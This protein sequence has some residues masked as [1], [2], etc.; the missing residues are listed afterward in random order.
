MDFNNIL[1]TIVLSVPGFLMAIV[2][3]EWAHAYVAYRFGD[4]TALK[5]GRLT[6]NPAAHYDMLGTVIFPLIGVIAGFAAIG[7][8]KPV[9]INAGNFKKNYQRRALFWVSFAGPMAN[10]LIGVTCAFLIAI[11]SIHFPNFSYT[12]ILLKMLGYAINLNFL[13]GAFNLIPLPPLD[14]ARMVSSCLSYNSARKFDSI[15]EYSSMIFLGLM[16]LSF[17]GV[18]IL[19]QLLYPAQF[20]VEFFIN[21][22]FLMLAP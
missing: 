3:H 21:L 9:P 16:A 17:A 5:M 7:W 13:I 8:A 12:P 2:I 18:N 19:G 10:F 22:F 1:N 14:G 11:L 15:A 4:N 20:A 6:L